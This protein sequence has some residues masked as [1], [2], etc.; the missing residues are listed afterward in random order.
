SHYRWTECPRC[1]HRTDA[2]IISELLAT[3]ESGI[4][5]A[6]PK[7][8]VLVSDWGWRRHGDAPDIIARLPKSVWL[9]SVSEWAKPIERGGIKTEVGEYSIS[10]VG[11]GPRALRHWADARKAGLKIAAEIQFNNSCEIASVPYLPVM[12]LIAEHLRNL[13]SL[14]LDGM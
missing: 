8:T 12:N 6:S 4:H 2:D 14:K 13:V 9:L 5:R 11:P 10:A 1:K 7:A 3:I